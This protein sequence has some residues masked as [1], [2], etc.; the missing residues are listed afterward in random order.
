M[1]QGPNFTESLVGINYTFGNGSDV[2]RS[3]S[4][5]T[6]LILRAL[7]LEN[8]TVVQPGTNATIWVST[9][10]SGYDGGNNGTTNTTG[11]FNVSFDPSCSY[12]PTK[13]A[14]TGGIADSCYQDANGS[15]FN[16][17]VHASMHLVMVSPINADEYLVGSNVTLSANVT[18]ECSAPVPGSTVNLTAQKVASNNECT[19]VSDES[20]GTYN[21]TINT[22]G[23]NVGFFN[24]SITANRTYYN[25]ESNVS[26][27]AFFLET[28]PVLSN[29]NVT[30]SN[31]GWGETFNY[32]VLVSDNDGDN[33]TVYLWER[34]RTGQ[35]WSNLYSTTLSGINQTVSFTKV[36]GSCSFYQ[37]ENAREFLWN[38]TEDDIWNDT[39][40]AINYS[41]EA[42]E[43]YFELETGGNVSIYR[44]GGDA[45]SLTVQIWDSDTD[46]DSSLGAG[47]EGYIHL[48]EDGENFSATQVAYTNSS[49]HMRYIFNPSC[50]YSVGNQT[51][52][53]ELIQP[54][55]G[56]YVAGNS[57]NNTYNITTALTI[58][59]TN[60]H[61]ERFFRGQDILL[62]ANVTD[63]CPNPVTGLAT[64]MNATGGSNYI[65]SSVNDS[66]DG[67]YNC[68]I[69]AASTN[70]MA[71]GPYNVTFQGAK[72][73]YNTTVALKNTAF[74][75]TAVPVLT[76]PTVSPSTDGWG[77]RY[78][79]NVTVIDIEGDDVTVYLWKRVSFGS[80]ALLNQT[81]QTFSGLETVSFYNRFTC[82][83]IG[84]NDFKFNA[85]DINNNT[86]ETTNVSFT[87]TPDLPRIDF[88][89]G[90]GGDA[91]V[92]EGNDTKFLEVQVYDLDLAAYVGTGVNVSFWATT[93][94]VNY[95]NGNIT[96]TDG[97]AFAN[98]NFDPSCIHQSMAQ[99]WVAGT[100]NNSCY[101][102]ANTST[103][104]PITVVGQL[105]INVT[106]PD[107]N[108]T[109]PVGNQQVIKVNITD[110]CLIPRQN[111]S[112]Q[113][114][115][116][117]PGDAEEECSP[118]ANESTG[119]YNCTWDTSQH[120]GGAWDIHSNATEANYY[121]NSTFFLDWLNLVNTPPSIG[122]YTV[123]PS[124]GGWSETF[125]YEA[126]VNDTQFDNVTCRLFVTT[127]N[128]T[129]WQDRGTDLI[130]SGVGRCQVNVTNYA[131][132]EIG[133]DN[134]WLFQFEDGTNTDNSSNQT[135]FEV[136]A[137]DINVSYENVGNDT[138]VNRTGS[139]STP[140]ILRVYNIDNSSWATSGVNGT[141]WVTSDGSSFESN[142][143]QTNSSGHLY[144]DYEPTCD[145]SEGA[146]VWIGGVNNDACY[147]AANT[148]ENYST[149]VWGHLTNS[150]SSPIGT[151][152][153]QGN[154]VSMLAQVADDCGQDVV[155]ANVRFDSYH[156]GSSQN[157]TCS[158]IEEV[159]SGAYNCS[160]WTS[161][162][163]ANWWTTV[164]NGSK[165]FFN[166]GSTTQTHAFFV[167]TAP[168]LSNASSIKDL[169]GWGER[170]FFNV[171]VTDDDADQVFVRLWTR[172]IG[173]PSWTEQNSTTINNPTNENVSLSTQIYTCADM[174]DM[175]FY[176]TASDNHSYS[177]N[178]SELNF[179]L[180]QDDARIDFY[181]LDNSKVYRNG[182]ADTADVALRFYDNDTNTTVGLGENATIWV[183]YDNGTTWDNGSL[184]GTLSDGW[185]NYSFD[186][187]CT[188]TIGTQYLRG[189]S[190]HNTCYKNANVSNITLQVWS[191]LRPEITFPNGNGYLQ[192]DLIVI[193]TQVRDDC[194]G[195]V[196]NATPAMK[197]VQY[198]GLGGP[199]TC[200]NFSNAGGTYNCTW[201]STLQPREW[202]NATFNISKSFYSS[203]GTIDPYAFFVGTAPG[204]SEYRINSTTGGWTAGWG[205]AYLFSVR[206]TDFDQNTNNVSLWKSDDN[207]SWNLIEMQQVFNPIQTQVNFVHRFEC[208][209][210]GYNYFKI[211]TTDPFNFTDETE[212]YSLN[213]ERDDVVIT[214]MGDS[215]TSIRRIA[216]NSA[217]MRFTFYDSDNVTYP[218]GSIGNFWISKDGGNLTVNYTCATSEGN[219][220]VNFDPSC[221]YNAARQVW[222][223]GSDDSCYK[224]VNT[225]NQTLD[226]YGQLY[227]NF[228]PLIQGNY[229][230]RQANFTFNSTINDECS[231]PVLAANTTW[232]NE[233]GLVLAQGQNTTWEVPAL[234]KRGL[235]TVNLTSN[236]SY[237]DQGVNSSSLTVFGWSQVGY[238]AP[239]NG[240]SYIAGQTV[241][242][243]CR[244]QDN[245]TNSYIS[246]YQVQFWKD[247]QWQQ[248][249]STDGNGSASW[250]WSTTTDT[251][252][253]H[254]VSCNMTGDAAKYY[255]VSNPENS[256]LILINRDFIIDSYTINPTTIYRND[257]YSPHEANFTVH[258]KDAL[259]TAV[260][261]NVS[262]YNATPILVG[263]CITDNDGYCSILHNVTD[264]TTPGNYTFYLNASD[265]NA[266]D[267]ATN[268]TWLVIQGVL[269]SN[270][271]APL[272]GTSYGKDETMDLIASVW[273]E[274]GNTP[275][276][277]ITWFN[278]TGAVGSGTP[279]SL[280]L[281]TQLTGVRNFTIQSS[282][283]YYDSGNDTVQ[284]EIFG[285]SNVQVEYPPD[286][287]QHPYPNNVTFT[288][289]VT[290]SESGDGVSNYNVSFYSNFTA[291][292]NVIG[293][294]TTNSTGQAS[295][296]FT[297]SQKGD[298]TLRCIIFD[299]AEKFYSA[300][301]NESIVNINI[302]DL[303]PP[304][305]T[306]ASI[307]PNSSLEANLNITNITV[308]VT[309][310]TAIDYVFTRIGLP[311]GTTEDVNMTHDGNNTYFVEYLPYN[312]GLHNAT[313]WAFDQP[314][315]SNSNY[316]FA[317]NFSVWGQTNATL[318]INPLA[319]T[320]T[321]VTQDNGYAFDLLVNYTVTGPVA[322]NYTNLTVADDSSSEI[323]YNESLKDCGR[324]EPNVTCY[325]AVHV[326][327]LPGT[328]PK[329]I[330][331]TTN[332]TWMNADITQI[333]IS[334]STDVIVSSNPR[335][336][337]QPRGINATPQHG[338]IT[339]LGNLSVRSYGNDQLLGVFTDTIGGNLSTACPGCSLIMFP[340]S[341]DSLP[342]GSNMS[343]DVNVSVPSGQTPGL[344]WTYIQVNSSNDGT[345]LSLINLDIPSNGS[346]ISS[347]LTF[348]NISVSPNT[349]GT[350]GNITIQNIGNIDVDLVFY[351]QGD[352]QD[353]TIV[354][355]AIDLGKQVSANITVTYVIPAG[356]TPGLYSGQISIQSTNGTPTERTIPITLNV[357]DIPPI[358]TNVTATPPSFEVTD[359]NT[360]IT[361]NITDN[362]VVSGAWIYV[363]AQ[364]LST[365]NT[366]MT[367][368]GSIY[369]ASYISSIAGIHQMQVCANDSA[370]LVT[371]SNVSNLTIADTTNFSI[372]TNV[373]FIQI[374]NVTQSGSGSAPL[375]ISLIN[376]G[377]ARAYNVSANL[378]ST[379]SNLSASPF[380]LHYAT[381]LANGTGYNN[382]VAVISNGTAPGNYTL[383]LTANWTNRNASIA[384][385]YSLLIVEVLSNPVL[386]ISEE[387]ISMTISSSDQDTTNMTLA[388]VGNAN[389]STINFT[390]ASGT[391]CSD[392]SY[393]FS[394]NSI[395][396][397]P[398]GTN[399]RVN[400]TISV[401]FA[402]AT[403]VYTGIIFAN[404]TSNTSDQ[405]NISI[406]VPSNVS[407]TQSPS[408]FN[409]RVIAGTSNI[410]GELT[411][412]NIG[413]NVVLL[414]LLSSNLSTYVSFNVSNILLSPGQTGVVQVNYSAPN[415]TA[416]SIYIGTVYTQNST[417][418]PPTRSSAVNLTVHPY[419]VNITQPSQLNPLTNVDFGE[420]VSVRVNVSYANVVLTQNV[421]FNLSLVSGTTYPIT[422]SSSSYVSSIGLWELNF[423][424]PNLPTGVSYDINVTA[425]DSS[426]SLARSDAEMDALV[427]TDE[428]KPTIAFILETLVIANFTAPIQVNATDTGG[429]ANVTGNLTYPNA[430]VVSLTY[431]LAY[432]SGDSY[433]YDSNYSDTSRE[434]I[435]SVSATTCDVSGNCN[436]TTGSFEVRAAAYFSGIAYDEESN[437]KP[438]IALDWKLHNKTEIDFY[439]L[440]GSVIYNFS[441]NSTGH[442]NRTVFVNTYGI[443][444]TGVNTMVGFNGSLINQNVH[445]P[446]KFGHIPSER[447]G[448][449][450]IFGTT[451]ETKLNYT[452]RIGLSLNYSGYSGFFEPNLGLYT[453]SNYTQ[454]SGC[455]SNW[456]R[457]GGNLNSSGTS[458][459]MLTNNLSEGY[460]LAE[461]VCGNGVCETTYGESTSN[462]ALDCGVLNVTVTPTAVA[463]VV[464]G[465]GGPGGGV[466]S[467]GETGTAPPG[468]GTN[469]S[470]PGSGTT[471][472]TLQAPLEVRS[473][474]LYVILQPGESEVHSMDLINNLAED[475]QAQITVEGGI[476]PYLSLSNVSLSVGAGT[477]EVVHV[478]VF[479]PEDAEPDIYTGDILIRMGDY[480]HR[481][482]VTLK[483][484][485]VREPTLE[486]KARALTKTVTPGNE[487]KAEVSFINRGE[488]SLVDNVV[489]VY[490]V[491][492][493]D[494][495][496]SIVS[497]TE[498]L[499]VRD[500]ITR[501]V[502][503]EIPVNA[504]PGKYVIQARATYFDGRKQSS[505]A[506]SFDLVTVPFT[507][508]VVETVI[509]SPLTYALIAL[510]LLAIVGRRAY[511]A[512]RRRQ[513]KVTR[514]I[515][516]LDF[517]KL[518]QP[519]PRSIVTGK[520]AETDVKSYVE[521]ERLTTHSIAAGGTGSGKSVSAQ[522]IAE[523]MLMRKL[524][525]VVFDPTAQWTG[526]IR[527]NKD[528]GMLSL[529]PNFGLR[530]EDARGFKVNIIDVTDPNMDIN[531][532]EHFKPGEMTVFVMN[533]LRPEQL[534]SLVRRS[535]DSIFHSNPKESRELK[536]M[537]IYDEVH[538]LL[539]K[540]GGK[541]AYTSIERGCREFRKWGIGIFLISQVL[542]DFKGAVRAN[543]A[544]EI[545]L[546][547]RYE[548]DIG[549]VK[550]KYGAEYADRVTKLTVGTGLY[551]N[552]EY[553]DGK[554]WFVSF[555]PLL[556]STFSLT[557]EEIKQFTTIR[558]QIEDARKQL[559]ELKSH[560]VDTYDVELELNIASDKL[561]QGLTR[562]AQNYLE[563]VNA[564]IKGMTRR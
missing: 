140:L 251:P 355:P 377:Y 486:V 7:D 266:S 8:N 555:R 536:A 321:G 144:L 271:T 550:T 395:S 201:D 60:P 108:T 203:N 83:D 376:T 348:G 482:P 137:N 529:Y 237:Y 261:A 332:A 464:P 194:T 316:T 496:T 507:A 21:C 156:E 390:C 369:N 547:T 72:T 298:A 510:L 530:P 362:F 456:S 365:T 339:Q 383:N 209:D 370:G 426:R 301:Q 431:A 24:V 455:G 379:T 296:N 220:T 263:F 16:T 176:F 103:T 487:L 96:T 26:V 177:V 135:G 314:P 500:V 434:G 78:V 538:R 93:D 210:L 508:L 324:V 380:W 501:L 247:L 541:G 515:M 459:W 354:P 545:Q 322:S 123:S 318:H 25:N 357:S 99:K 360:T 248:T 34:N 319:V 218:N 236:N 255:N 427:Y 190:D 499:S 54:A 310:D 312:D 307:I 259:A 488:T 114:F 48:T 149:R 219:C 178:T 31:G 66:G 182:S 364:D 85:S 363:V 474:L 235:T 84:G 265:T 558:L 509:S 512:Y 256:T 109:I 454:F 429:I 169:G 471:P 92:R 273:D 81:T 264:T 157:T 268:T 415:V 131:C 452:N 295:V 269:I 62:K 518:P 478:T 258:V 87:I 30:P 41:L 449:G 412:T 174:G 215:N 276:T 532:P 212:I 392:F 557:E 361:A 239:P 240:S 551:Q 23:F 346:W 292:Y 400:I 309:D 53:A 533:K 205:E 191:D 517:K 391:V 173:A 562:M 214:P 338:A 388:S 462:C 110:E 162:L 253:Y 333:S 444:A 20:D 448:A 373:T 55:G 443:I 470:G 457:V 290:D 29:P 64:V 68:T 80:W 202:Y 245:N 284:V 417:A 226:V 393:A 257:T 45:R 502:A 168:V 556:H 469:V 249:S 115:L 544:S 468:A 9:D 38:V 344:Y 293:N 250:L 483:I 554:P 559:A 152:V 120:Q 61:Y 233:T 102:D 546:R 285:L 311:N 238:I 243:E 2:N 543:I 372:G 188:Y 185:V 476:V 493:L 146:Q 440:S 172:D 521:M 163:S 104:F 519:G 192:G 494:D 128:G 419:Y 351:K 199:K 371:C 352:L 410:L 405:I 279:L 382:T 133:D 386:N 278:E 299:D 553:N 472:P 42:D 381:I 145:Y 275:A 75:L 420:N 564:R 398:A 418:I 79:F 117:S 315:E 89:Q 327:I 385:N 229:T 125:T 28:T 328:P 106:Q 286:A 436:S 424:A 14:W 69:P 139:N 402:Y 165:A 175:E 39:T 305:F 127:N 183:T 244:I 213:F 399:T 180:E 252:G 492:S 254:N 63:E 32:S 73:F 421:S 228:N 47:F 227:S 528:K 217:Y 18:D 422:L 450:A 460:A 445:D 186:P 401:P 121:S 204:L 283:S 161:N 465:G 504:P 479:A 198:Q 439:N 347:P 294:A 340:T 59:I 435:Y 231:Q 531:I 524:P 97:S 65:C 411:L 124:L 142:T 126:D 441:A 437:S 331:I 477:V 549:R 107:F 526:F 303:V 112:T 485:S 506:D 15:A 313:I 155:G 151:S 19:P 277:L 4:N 378:S 335:I 22:T 425:N 100:L 368:V 221:D 491:L 51:W 336:G 323:A 525:I 208:A 52:L 446:V 534:D 95:D 537:I 542:L 511:K 82:T 77:A 90:A 516:P 86:N 366:T 447:I 116:R 513:R 561:K 224:G 523:E 563:S 325:W 387:S 430:T 46:P 232:Y 44:P 560:G 37:N 409:S 184:T 342:A 527:P 281:L 105:L 193:K 306:N 12:A 132:G 548:G 74:N 495:E 181:S 403:G 241:T 280:P 3:G 287:S 27:N 423:T 98:L 270:I 119:Q 153:T 407:W 334:N 497:E 206:V 166:N 13:Q 539:P 160:Q 11:H 101:Q 337:L 222:I 197:V 343:I 246:S 345:N 1:V 374:A 397:L 262:L 200:S 70:T 359:G 167:E 234:Y 33:V 514:Y 288:C 404:S 88:S 272:N 216:N 326:T 67:T 535:I 211:N 413:N 58:N 297:P 43:I 308:V 302:L 122:N 134:V 330:R 353:L 111:A 466:V 416:Y 129:L 225:T 76:N 138:D 159:G 171:I 282:L 17:T 189:G 408:S 489:A 230:N 540:Y 329:L 289:R 130:V 179:T 349:S 56:C 164:F 304:Q 394:P 36:F 207:A 57:T 481:T 428:I 520:I 49:G 356:R 320:A 223:G 267:S 451:I 375:N 148:T 433:Y 406:T 341:T 118:I 113:I 453:C 35:S 473:T 384:Q 136:E 141:F 358:I 40:A 396:S 196:E 6:L 458:V 552:A 367:G 389:I 432:S 158:P 274:N 291:G 484:E 350:I 317:G 5:S 467:E 463:T 505:A 475:M 10:G 150:I 461:Y 442:Y 147:K 503:L 91:I 170:W 522:V 195:L 498:T 143:N 242:V 71:T 300:F 260:G 438:V 480:S 414:D 94:N 490:E 154:N 187:S 50:D